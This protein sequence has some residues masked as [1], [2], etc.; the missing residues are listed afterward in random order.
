MEREIVVKAWSNGKPYPSGGGYGLRMSARDR[1]SIFDQAWSFVLIWLPGNSKPVKVNIAKESF[2]KEC[3]ELISKEIGKWL[4]ESGLAPW[5]KG[6]PP[7]FS[8]RPTINNEFVL[9]VY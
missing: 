7:C 8:L 2:W 4:L 5:T 1:D 3:P 9:T 6:H